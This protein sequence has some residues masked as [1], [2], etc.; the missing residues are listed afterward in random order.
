V[1]TIERAKAALTLRGSGPSTLPPKVQACLELLIEIAER[2]SELV[3]ALRPL[4]KD[5]DRDAIEE[6]ARVRPKNG[7]Q[8][9]H[10]SNADMLKLIRAYQRASDQV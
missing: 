9:L 6:E 5:I 10:I 8:G 1:S 2:D 3:K 7:A 4:M